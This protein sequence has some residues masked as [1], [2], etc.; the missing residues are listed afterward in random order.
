MKH[1]SN[2]RELACGI[3]TNAQHKQRPGQPRTVFR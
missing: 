1:T 2:A 3:V